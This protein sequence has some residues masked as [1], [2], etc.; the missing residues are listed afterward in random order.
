MD[1]II[2]HLMDVVRA[3]LPLNAEIDKV[4]THGIAV[5]IRSWWGEKD[6]FLVNIMWDALEDYL[7]L[8]DHQRDEADRRL[9]QI[10]SEKLEKG[11]SVVHLSSEQLNGEKGGESSIIMPG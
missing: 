8:L 6:K 1:K 3:Q 11:V 5:L 2:D 10:A 7:D 9:I 4:V